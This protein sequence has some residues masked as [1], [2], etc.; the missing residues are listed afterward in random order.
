MGG[1]RRTGARP[2][3]RETTDAMN[4]LR[5]LTVEVTS[6]IES[7][8][9]LSLPQALAL[10]A[11]GDGAR[12]VSE[13]ARRVFAHVSSASRVVD[14]LVTAGL[15]TR[16]PDPDDRRAVLL[17]VT[18]DGKLMLEEL[19]TVRTRTLG[20]VIDRL[21]EDEVDDLNRVIC[22]L[23]DAIEETFADEA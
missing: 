17:E 18:A 11:V 4:R 2:A 14:Q 23:A 8:L 3:L 20:R 22:R 5:R 7:E 10:E 9:S 6:A 16:D 12:Q 15:V 19:E 21:D 13:V 1:T